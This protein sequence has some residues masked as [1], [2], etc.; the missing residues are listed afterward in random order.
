VKSKLEANSSAFSHILRKRFGET[1]AD[2]SSCKEKLKQDAT[3]EAIHHL[4]PVFV[5]SGFDIFDANEMMFYRTSRMF[6]LHG[7]YNGSVVSWTFY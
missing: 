6:R 3:T 1:L 4:L 7:G 2:F 5:G